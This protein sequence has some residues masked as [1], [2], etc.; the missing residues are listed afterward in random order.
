MVFLVCCVAGLVGSPAVTFGASASSGARS[1]FSSSLSGSPLV[2]PG[3]PVEGEQLW[4]QEE[5]WRHS[6]EAVVERDISRTKFQNLSARQVALLAAKVF[7]VLVDQRAGGT[8]SLPAGQHITSYLSSNV[9]RLALSGGKRGVI[10]SAGAMAR[11]TSRGNFTP[12]D[13]GLKDAGKDYVP[14]SSNVAV[15]IPRRLS[16]GVKAA[17]TGVSLT[18]IDAQGAALGN[19]EGSVNGTSVIYPNTQTAMDTVAKPTS[20]GFEISAI[21]RSIDSPRQLYYRVGMPSGASLVQKHHGGPIQILDKGLAIATVLTPNAKDAAGMVVPVTISVK[22][23][24]L[25]LG[26]GSDSGEWL[27]P[28]TVDPEL[29][30]TED[31]S[32]T[33]AVFPIEPYKGGTAWVPIKSSSAF[34]YEERYS[35]GTE[36]Y[37]CEQSWNIEP[38][39]SYSGGDFAGIQYETQG[40]SKAYKVEAWILGNNEPSQARTQIEFNNHEGVQTNHAVL[41]EG[42]HYEYK[43]ALVGS[44]PTSCGPSETPAG[45]IVRI[46]DDMTKSGSSGFSTYI[47]DARVYVAQEK[48]PTTTFNTSSPTI[49]EAGYRPNVLYGSGSWL[50]P[51]SGAYEVTAHDP[52]I[53]VSFVA[54]SGAGMSQERFIRNQLGKCLGIQCPQT[55]SSPATY[56]PTMADGEDSIELFAENAAGLNGYTYQT[57]KVDKTPPHNLEVSGWPKNREISAAPHTL[58]IEATDGTK[59]TPSS[60]VRSISVGVD[61]G[62]ESVIPGATCSPGE[63]TAGGKYTLNAES[64]TEGVHKLIVTAIDNAGN[65]APSK[66]W[67]FDVRHA[68]PVAIGPGTVD[69]TTGQFALRATDV[70]LGGTSGVSRVY[71]SRNL[72]GGAGGPLGSQWAIS[73]GAGESLVVLPEGSV[74]LVASNGG[75]TTF[76]RNSKGEFESP[77]GDS[78]LK[79]EPKEPVKGKGISEYWLV[80]E[81]AGTTIHFTQPTGTDKTTPIY[82]EQFGAEGAELNH[83][84]SDAVDSNGNVWVIDSGNNRIEKFSS[85]GL[86]IAPYGEIGS[87][88]GEFSGPWGIAVNQST[89]NVYVTDQG[90]NR[91]EELSSTGS[92]IREFG[93]QGTGAG[94]T[95]SEAGIA[96]DSNGNVW[97]ADYGNNR[98]QEFNEKGEFIEAFGFGVSNGEEKLEVCTSGCRVGI[99]GSGTGQFKGPLTIALS[100]GHLYVTDYGNSR[101]QEFSTAG[102]YIS[103]FGSAGSGNGQFTNPWGIAS[104][105]NTGN[106]YVADPG[107]SRVQEFNP[108]GGYIAKFGSAGTGNGQ[109]SSPLGVVVNSSGGIYVADYSN[110]RVQ[111]WTRPTWLPTLAEGPLSSGT[112][113]YAYGPVEEEGQTVIEPLEASAPAPVGITCGT[114]PEELKKGCRAL[115]FE[116]AKETTA[117]GEGSSEWGDYKGHLKRV[118]FHGWDPSK[119][120]MTKEVFVAQYAYDARGRLRAEWDPRIAPAP[121]KTTYGYD[122][123]GHITALTPPGQE[124]WMFTYGT[125]VGDVNSGRLLTVSRPSASTAFGT[126]T[127]PINTAA[128]ALSTNS[129]LEGTSLS[130]TDG[131]WNNS[132]LSYGYQWEH[133]HL[134]GSEEVCTLIPGATNQKYTPTYTDKKEQDK[135]RAKVSATNSDG[136][137]VATSATSATVGF[138]LSSLQ[139]KSSFGAYGTVPGDFNAPVGIAIDS[140]H[141][142]VYVVDKGNQR[143]ERFTTGGE[144][145]N[146]FGS[147]R[148]FSYLGGITVGRIVLVSGCREICK[149]NG[150]GEWLGEMDEFHSPSKSA[151]MATNYEAREVWFTS[152]S[153]IWRFPT[154]GLGIGESFGGEGTENGKFKKP[155][156]LAL[157]GNSLFVADTGNN[158]VQEVSEK[159]TF[160]QMLGTEGTGNGQFKAPSA[161]AASSQVVVVADTG[162]NR[163]EVFRENK[164]TYEYLFQFGTTGSSEGQFS[165]PQGVAVSENSEEV[166]IADTANNRVQRWV[167]PRTELEPPAEPPNTGKNSVSTVE[168]HVPVSGTGAPYAL[169][170]SE[171][172]KWGQKDDPTEATAIFPPDE[173]MGW[174]ASGYKRASIT[175][176][177]EEGRTVNTVSPSGAISTTEYNETNDVVRTLSANNRAAALKEGGKSAEVSKQ[178]DTQSTYNEAGTELLETLEPEHKVKLTSGSEVQARDRVKYFYDEGAP[179]EYAHNGLVTKTTDAALVSG[180]EEDVRTTQTSYSGQENLGWKLRKPTSVDKDSNG[181]RLFSVTEYDPTTGNV[182]KTKSPARQGEDKSVPPAFSL[183]FGSSGSGGGQFEGPQHDAIDSHGNLWVTDYSNMRIQEFSSSGTFMLAVGWGVK[184][185]KAEAETCTTAC[186]AGISG[187]GNGQFEG[188][189]G[190]AV[191]QSSGNVYVADYAGSRVEEFSSTGGF[192]ASFGSKG[193]GGGQFSS[194]EGVAVDSSGD[195][196]ISDSGNN[197]IQEFSS[198]GTFMLAVGWGVK[199]GKAEAETCTT[200]CQAGVGG[201]GNGQV[202]GPANIAFSGGNVYISDYGNNRVDEFSASGAY[203]SRFGSEGSGN[204]QFKGPFDIATEPTSGN[205]YV[206]DSGNHRV[207]KFKATGTFLAT[208]GSKGSGNGQFPVPSGVTVNSSGDVYV[209]DRENNRIQEWVP[210]IT[211]NQNTHII[212]TIYYSAG[213]ES[214]VPACRNHPE[215]ADLPCQ[216]QPIAQ[217]E[218]SPL[219]VSTVTYNLW[220]EVEK[221]EEQFGSTTRIKAQ[222]YDAAGRAI[223]SET[224]STIDTALPKVT[225]EY[226]KETGALEKQSTEKEGKTKKVTSVL[227]TLGQLVSYTDADGNTTTYEYEPEGD[228]RLTAINDGKGTQ[229]YA[230]DP[231]TGILT[232]LIDSAAGTFTASYDVE[233]KMT[234]ESYPNGMTANYTR[235][236]LGQTTGLS[237]EKTT[238]CATKCPETW[239]S[240]TIVPSIHGETLVQTST[241]AK[242]NYTFDTA[243]R[244]TQTQEEPA[245]KGCTTRVY[246]YDEEADRTSL[247]TREPGSEGKCATEGGSTEWH[248]YDTANRLTDTGV[249]YETFG[250]TTKLSTADAGGGHELTSSYYIDNQVASQTQNEETI[251]YNY[252][253]TG[254]TR[255]TISTGKT[256]AT[257]ISHYSGAG[258]ALTWTSEEEGKKWSRNIPGLDGALDVIQTSS[259]SITLQL[260]DLRGNIVATAGINETE[261]KLLSTYNSTEFGVPQPGTTPPKYA[262]LGATGVS[263]EP[264]LSSGV[265]TKG[266]ASY[267]PQVAR[268]LQTAPVVPPGAFPNGIG[269]GAPYTATVSAASLASAQAIA[270]QIFEEAEAARQAAARRKAEEACRAAPLSCIIVGG[271]P[272]PKITHL[273]LEQAAN[274]ALSIREW[275]REGDESAIIAFFFDLGGFAE[276]TA[277]FIFTGD[278]VKKWDEYLAGKLE[279]CVS[280][281]IFWGAEGGGCRVSEPTIGVGTFCLPTGP[282]SQKCETILTLPDLSKNPEVSM[283]GEWVENR[284]GECIYLGPGYG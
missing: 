82:T 68:S 137:A 94:E 11:E 22:G 258:E 103:Q 260:H 259:G 133:C 121:L 101:V 102:V 179:S 107:N 17:K 36:T 139:Y 109:F 100:G 231:T 155:K 31:R 202:Y 91:I 263:T 5:A 281:L 267:V 59:P 203:I 214:S 66:E 244:L 164:G 198:S 111:E 99:G 63:C 19:S 47:W 60:G 269:S 23:D 79:I 115:T 223:T 97:V 189:F 282:E 209:S 28:I 54:V 98:V 71:Q 30:T 138:T 126:G 160:E 158:R 1:G 104:D 25:V 233:G 234:S 77:L 4:A 16:N 270:K 6:S 136:T 221:T 283:C 106:L 195:V 211:G 250:N 62:K 86:L 46:M 238:H 222:T 196:W 145:L 129:P 18:P 67:T 42:P 177:D 182:T 279:Y 165:E 73:M 39:S 41:S 192:V 92:F 57:I 48:G 188:P 174:P 153:S 273:T 256:K 105:P 178:L 61:G 251:T 157:K 3:S 206:A 116:Y 114:K 199:D 127:S 154:E 49:A 204:G 13:L 117:K 181:L 236:Q 84:S 235:N 146:A 125:I 149:Y 58:T 70:S 284:L 118:E 226:N 280:E 213:T 228:D 220:D 143:V 150:F 88:P 119:G 110:N 9:A 152:G 80:D 219:P 45:N 78:N 56:L 245:G 76:T 175:Y 257:V 243:G 201:A 248:T 159:G 81:A 142:W 21:L 264:G 200:S 10:E 72:G 277:E 210:T 255:E 12:I 162:N 90:N 34:R 140:Q 239:F 53:G 130:V 262:W 135:L 65:P 96:V 50:G 184:D 194:P 14:V 212:Q 20:A 7:P 275:I 27:W 29:T 147:E 132:P 186:R 32:L 215:W 93:K 185:G 24:S 225:N 254:R 35:C 38:T 2:I 229:T 193:T 180:K 216:T 276:E 122:A 64:L 37:W 108:S 148:L 227:N 113:T 128:P 252:D 208:F 187:S 166:F 83:P 230:Y 156:G 95:S 261:T 207:Q 253:P 123:E 237:Y 8:P 224:T 40:E 26:V 163:I 247:T 51:H 167:S 87:G 265:A 74:V 172:A 176:M 240:D 69:P 217:P 274:L 15:Q 271:D 171:V 52:G 218:G 141:S 205:L 173:P 190:I 170:S 134:Y 112:T 241:L 272:E 197:R 43:P 144:F 151:S 75:R 89:G 55:I 33:G 183:Q 85:A 268:D 246:A 232:K 242:E 249:S 168:Y 131:T 278:A 120:A 161:I 44:C 266:G 169:G 191:N 124:S